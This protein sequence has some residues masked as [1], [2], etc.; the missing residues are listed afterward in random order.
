MEV[1]TLPSRR[2]ARNRCRVGVERVRWP[3]ATGLGQQA[4]LSLFPDA[5]GW[6]YASGAGPVLGLRDL[7]GRL[8]LS[9][10]PERI[11]LRPGFF[12]ENHLRGIP[13]IKQFGVYGSAFAPDEPVPMIAARDVGHAAT[14]ALVEEPFSGNCIR[15][16]LGP[17]DYTM[18]EAAPILGAAIGLPDLRYVQ[19]PY[20]R[21][22]D[23]MLRSGIAP[24][25]ADAIMEIVRSFNERRINGRTGRTEKNSMPTHLEEFARETFRKAFENAKAA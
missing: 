22:K 8:E 19:F 12:M 6:E 23:G 7:E 17:R 5:L 3:T 9:G 15:E 10:V 24:G 1:V 18:A 25:Y 4:R 20:D 11:Y 2:I 13:G 14:Q 21:V 16:L